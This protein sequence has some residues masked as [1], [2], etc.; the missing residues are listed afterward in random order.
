MAKRAKRGTVDVRAH[1]PRPGL[2]S[3]EMSPEDAFTEA[4]SF[5]LPIDKVGGLRNHSRRRS[6]RIARRVK[7]AKG[8]SQ[9]A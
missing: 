4:D 9:N 5:A 2:T 7:A 1:T 8:Y 6:G 3:G